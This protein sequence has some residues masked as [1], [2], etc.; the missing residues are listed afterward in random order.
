MADKKIEKA[1]YGPST[2]EVALGAVL[3]LALGVAVACIYLVLK[4]VQ[5]VKET[6]KEVAQGVVYYL[7]GKTDATK[8]RAWQT[9]QATFVSGGEIIA[10]EEELNAWAASL[11]GA[12]PAAAPGAAP[13]APAQPGAPAAPADSAFLSASGLNFRLEGERMHVSQKVLFNY[14][15][16]T[17]EVILQS[18]GGFTRAGEGFVF[19]PEAVYLGS[20]PLHAVPGT[21]G[22]LLG[23]LLK[24]QK[25]PDDFRAAWA[26][27]SAI[28][29]EGGL[30]KVT[31]QP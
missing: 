29:V 24:Q 20:C 21:T 30:L 14:F 10:T 31:T 23:T 1:L 8:G 25:V 16:L 28:A 17:K 2:L 18:A 9:K 19:Q 6:P 5:L 15:G 13:K 4:P 7:P 3:G 26:K 12:A 11:G 27:I 22:A